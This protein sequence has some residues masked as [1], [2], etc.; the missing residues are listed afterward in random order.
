M[1]IVLSA[2][3]LMGIMLL[4]SNFAFIGKKSIHSDAKSYRTRHCLVFYP[5]GDIGSKMA[6]ELCK[7]RKDDRIF[8]YSL[9]PYGDYYMVSYGEDLKYFVDQSYNALKIEGIKEDDR[10]IVLDYLRYTLKKEDPD[11][12]YNAEYLK[13]VDLDSIGFSS[14]TYSIEGEDLRLD[15]ADYEKT[16]YI[17]LRYAQ[18]AIGMDFGFPNETYRRP[19]YIDPERPVICLTF[20]D[21][22]Q[23]WY[24]TG[25]TSTEAILKTLY[26]YD[27]NAT[28]YVIGNNLEDRDIWSDYQVYNLLKTS[29]A[30]GNEYGSHT[31]THLYALTELS[32]ADEIYRAINGPIEFMRDFMDYEIKTYRPV[33]GAFDDNVLNA[34]PVGAVLWDIDSEDWLSMDPSTIVDRILNEDID[35]GD[36]IIFHDIY[37][38]TAEA[39]ETIIPELLNRGYQMVTV[40]DMMNYFKVDIDQFKFIFS[41]TDYR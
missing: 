3:L 1:I 18:K 31:Q 14:I 39:L 29:I 25:I 23:L 9:V 16:L 8:D 33:E 30:H 5:N 17:P 41:A 19:V 21:G 11:K 20:D 13:G 40:S 26:E 2:V 36:I 27:A 6:K 38:E 37:D 10:E 24:E 4:T 32:T 34:Q 7:G 12:Y 35:S 28:F 15:L 22:P